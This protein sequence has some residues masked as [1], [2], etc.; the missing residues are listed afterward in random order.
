MS[1]DP[2]ATQP[3]VDDSDYGATTP[4]STPE[5][6]PADPA[7]IEQLL[8]GLLGVQWNLFDRAACERALAAWQRDRSGPLAEV[9]LK[10]GAIDAPRRKMLEALLQKYLEQYGRDPVRSLESLSSLGTW[11]ER[12]QPQLEPGL[13]ATLAHVGQSTRSLPGTVRGSG[14]SRF[15]ILKPHARGGLGEVF[16]ARDEEVDRD[17]ALKEIQARYGHH[18]ESRARF[19][20]EA[21]ITGQ[22]EH[23]GIVPI[24]GLGTYEDGRP[25]YAMRFI[26]GESL[27]EAIRRFHA[28]HR[29]WN[30]TASREVTFRKLLQRFIDVCN[31]I[32]Y[33]HSKSILHRDLKPGNVMLGQYGET[34][35]VDW[36]LAKSV[37]DRT[38]EIFDPYAIFSSLARNDADL[39]QYGQ[40]LGTPS[41]MSPEQAAGRLDELGP[42]TD[43]YGLGAILYT[44]L[45]GLP[46]F[47]GPDVASTLLNVQQGLKE[48]RYPRRLNKSIPAGL[49]AVC[50]KAISPSP[51][52]RYAS[53]R[54][55]AADIES[56]LADG[57]VSVD[58]SPLRALARM[59]RK[60]RLPLVVIGMLLLGVLA[61]RLFIGFEQS[62][63]IQSLQSHGTYNSDMLARSVQVT[64]YAAN[65]KAAEAAIERLELAEAGRLLNPENC[66]PD[67]RG[68]EYQLVQRM[69]DETASKRDTSA[70]IFDPDGKIKIHASPRH[71]GRVWDVAVSPDGELIASAGDDKTVQVWS[72][73]ENRHLW[74]L[75]GH[76]GPI[77]SVAFTPDGTRL[78]SNGSREIKVWSTNEGK[79]ERSIATAPVDITEIAV[80]ADGKYIVG[81]KVWEIETGS[82]VAVLPGMSSVSSVA[83]STDG[84]RISVGGLAPTTNAIFD[85]L[86]FRRIEGNDPTI[87]SDERAKVVAVSHEGSR[88]A[89]GFRHPHTLRIKS[90]D[91]PAADILLPTEFQ[92]RCLEFSNDDRTLAGGSGNDVVLWDLE[93]RQETRLGGHNAEVGCVA[94]SRNGDFVVSGDDAGVVKFWNA[95]RN[96]VTKRLVVVD[97]TGPHVCRRINREG[98]RLLLVDPK[99][100]SG[101]FSIYDIGAAKHTV[102]DLGERDLLVAEFSPEGRFVAYASK[103]S[104]TLKVCDAASGQVLLN[105]V[106][107][108]SAIR[109][110]AFNSAGTRLASVD[111]ADEVI[112]WD[113][114]TGSIVSRFP[115]WSPDPDQKLSYRNSQVASIGFGEN[116]KRIVCQVS[117]YNQTLAKQEL[118]WK[119]WDAQTGQ[120]LL[121]LKRRAFDAEI[122]SYRPEMA[123]VLTMNKRGISLLDFATGQTVYSLP[124][125]RMNYREQ[126]AHVTLS[127][128]GQRLYAVADAGKLTDRGNDDHRYGIVIRTWAVDAMS[129]P[130][131]PTLSDVPLTAKK[132]DSEAVRKLISSVSDINALAFVR[133]EAAQQLGGLKIDESQ[134]DDVVQ[135][136]VD[137]LHERQRS[138]PAGAVLQMKFIDALG[139]FGPRAKAAVPLLVRSLKHSNAEMRKK[140]AVVLGKIGPDAGQAIP[141]LKELKNDTDATVYDAARVALQ[142]IERQTEEANAILVPNPSPTTP[143]SSSTVRNLQLP[144][145]EI[146]APIATPPISK[147]TPSHSGSAKTGKK[148][149][150]TEV[151]KLIALVKDPTESAFDRG[152]A[153]ERLGNLDVADTQA[154]EVVQALVDTLR[155]WQRTNPAFPELQIKLIDALGRFGPRA[156]AALPLLVRP[157]KHINAELRKKAAETLGKIGPDAKPAV[158]ALKELEYDSD[159][160]VR[161]A[162]AE[163]LRSI[164]LPK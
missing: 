46:P 86:S 157:T 24:Y 32:D 16:L 78:V 76:A 55:L 64:R 98:T 111:E 81:Q 87:Q 109:S 1:D 93:R 142:A 66:R 129:V 68:W 51:A 91:D 63:G 45:T 116:D 162:A 11:A 34:L 75:T 59:S 62:R 131:T 21:E 156:K 15:R 160:R 161:L 115:I 40:A 132:R 85:G 69:Y 114:A 113:T 29:P 30:H 123:R 108:G 141:G 10:Q 119:E 104:A 154:D 36:G 35:V 106:G 57:P 73:A 42:A 164:N 122:E 22:L 107:H 50:L 28:S 144:P 23:P 60:R 82:Q 8:C 39:T 148:S 37:G 149:V 143:Q 118:I 41:Y 61:V 135:A 139:G 13:Q 2:Y 155:E 67:L 72:I 163:A 5:P 99:Y 120:E 112:N 102:V 80:S 20:K 89:F 101:K 137:A 159:P 12:L 130:P 128:N 145:I 124:A 54:D 150:L 147:T 47:T 65:L 151:E 71:A 44:L 152:E 100:K 127:S 70:T 56:W 83:I 31:A 92:I 96:A 14:R 95:R 153:A 26:Q 6:L 48:Y 134:L 110:I 121:T 158:A 25:Y 97:D 18:E 9:L 146:P 90:F 133:G 77:R 4:P 58:R 53:A 27:D 126:Y 105:L 7:S 140:A 52:M 138:G 33:A 38:P 43:I 17:V 94:F 3:H 136:L 117:D 125:F 49:E 79:E 103:A 88:Y 84:S 19:L 74:T